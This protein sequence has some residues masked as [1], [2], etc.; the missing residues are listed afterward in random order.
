MNEFNIQLDCLI[1]IKNS[2]ELRICMRNVGRYTKP[3]ERN[4]KRMI[5]SRNRRTKKN[6]IKN[7]LANNK[8]KRK[9][10]ETTT[11]LYYSIAMIVFFLYLLVDSI[12]VSFFAYFITPNVWLRLCTMRQMYL[13]MKEIFPQIN[14]YDF[15]I[16][17]NNQHHHFVEELYV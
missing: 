4:R 2:N 17:T 16:Q 10:K 12:F 15:A 11:M 5:W 6:K 3:R 1:S 14:R 9:E 7:P 13:I 8:K